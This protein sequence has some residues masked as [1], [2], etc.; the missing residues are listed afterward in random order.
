MSILHRKNKLFEGQ[1]FFIEKPKV[2]AKDDKR[3]KAQPSPGL[4][5]WP[6]FRKAKMPFR[7]HAA[8]QIG[9]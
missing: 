7:P 6:D 3:P 9:L 5:S 2:K 1:T 4:S 8:G